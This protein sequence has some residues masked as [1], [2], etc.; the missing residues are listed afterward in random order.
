MS[1][2]H[3]EWDGRVDDF[4]G[5]K[6]RRLAR[7]V[8]ATRSALYRGNGKVVGGTPKQAVRAVGLNGILIIFE[9]VLKISDQKLYREG[10]DQNMW[11][12]VAGAWWHLSQVKMWY[13]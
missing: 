3:I 7:R 5:S 12:Y 2:I 4:H 13:F 8:K 6:I 10:Q 9:I 1:L 11:L